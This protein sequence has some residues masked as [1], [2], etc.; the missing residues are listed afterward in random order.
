M[1]VRNSAYGENYMDE[2]RPLPQVRCVPTIGDRLSS[3]FW[4]I[5]TAGVIGLLGVVFGPVL[6]TWVIGLGAAFTP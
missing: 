1:D 5:F 6:T 4:A 3:A 2:Y